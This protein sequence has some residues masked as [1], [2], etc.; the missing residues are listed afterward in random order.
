MYNY[1]NNKFKN[2]SYGAKSQAEAR[3]RKESLN[4]YTYSSIH[5]YTLI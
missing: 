3:K 1:I 2:N 4:G 5:Q